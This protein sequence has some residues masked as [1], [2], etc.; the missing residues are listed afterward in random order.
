MK[1]RHPP[2]N[3]TH[4]LF[5]LDGT[6]LGAWDF[7]LQIRFIQ[8]AL[9]AMKQR[10][11]LRKGLEAL[12]KVKL[13][14]E[15]PSFEGHNLMRSHTVTSKVLG[16]SVEEAEKIMSETIGG[17][18]PTLERFFFPI[19]GAQAFLAAVRERYT[20]ILATNPVWEP[21]II[22]LRVKWAGIDPTI[23]KSITDGTKMNVVKPSPKYYEKILKDEGIQ[24]NQC[25]LIGNDLR[26]DLSA[27][28]VGIPVFIISKRKQLREIT[29]DGSK[30]P[31]WTGNYAVLTEFLGVG[32]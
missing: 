19:K 6:I 11:G 27:V 12:I 29:P 2:K 3:L 5:D 10:S 15:N 17:L 23:F 22:E 31:A 20:L 9:K 32:R 8:K 4:L 14:L 30:V 25:M 28:S 13:E 26:N 21:S 16:V 1:H 18:F 7:P 24:A